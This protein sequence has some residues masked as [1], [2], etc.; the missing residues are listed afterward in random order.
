LFIPAGEINWVFPYKVFTDYMKPDEGRPIFP[1]YDRDDFPAIY[2]GLGGDSLNRNLL[3]RV[4]A[5]LKSN[6][7]ITDR[8]LRNRVTGNAVHDVAKFSRYRTGVWYSLT[9]NM[10][11]G[12]MEIIEEDL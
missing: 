7:K 10:R 11:N 5:D 9:V 2:E 12:A 4:F 1:Y 3:S 8:G 6:G